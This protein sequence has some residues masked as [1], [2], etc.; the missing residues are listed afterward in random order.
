MTRV[1]IRRIG[2]LAFE[3]AQ[4]RSGRLCSVDKANVLEVT[5]LWREVMQALSSE[6]PDVIAVPYVRR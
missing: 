4:K 1:E 3:A 2:R 6:Y 5:M